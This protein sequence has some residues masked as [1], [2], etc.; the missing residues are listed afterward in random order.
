MTTLYD[1]NFNEDLTE[2]ILLP[3]QVFLPARFQDKH[4][5][6][7]ALLY[8]ILDDAIE[9]L[10]K[11]RREKG[12]NYVREAQ[13]A[14]AW[15]FAEDYEWPFSFVNIC[16]HLG[17]DPTYLRRGLECWR[18]PRQSIPKHESPLLAHLVSL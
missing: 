16:E 10:Q 3:E 9:C 5:G 13:E 18:P 6:E 12:W 4:R 8:A 1:F 2:E 7:V 11:G 15:L 17:L 14:E